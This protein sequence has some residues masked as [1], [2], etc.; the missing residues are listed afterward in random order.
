VKDAYDHDLR[1][2]RHLLVPAYCSTKAAKM[3]VI[4][5]DVVGVMIRMT[6]MMM[7]AA[8]AAL[9]GMRTPAAV[10]VAVAVVVIGDQQGRPYRCGG[11][12]RRW[13]AHHHRHLQAEVPASSQ[14]HQRRP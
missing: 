12:H 3:A 11:E 7:M 13:S 2:H 1:P 10:A 6:M 8:A 14:S 9:V 4:G 5:T